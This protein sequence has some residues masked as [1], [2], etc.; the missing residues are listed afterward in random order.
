MSEQI[1]I[2]AGPMTV[3][4]YLPWAE[5]QPRGRFE[6]LDGQ[7]LAMAP[8]RA[9]HLRAKAAS[10]LALYSAIKAA[11]LPCEALPDGATLR[12][13][14]YTAYEPDVTVTCG[15]RMAAND[16]IAPNPVIVVEVTS[17]SNSRVDLTTKL[18]DYFRLPTVQHYLVVHIAKRVVIHHRRGTDGE[19]GTRVLPGGPIT[20]DPPG[21][22]VQVEDLF[23]A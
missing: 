11:R 5:A 2:P 14:D 6:L 17:P 15:E 1:E 22:T 9:A 8:E 3:E 21:L 16:L 18:A 13:D 19:I 7:V 20:L 4:E 10:F 23:E 12:I